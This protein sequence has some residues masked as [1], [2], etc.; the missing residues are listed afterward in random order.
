ME[1][2]YQS[3][4]IYEFFK[5]F[6]T[7]E[8]CLAHLSGLKWKDG[9]K[10]SKCGHGRYCRGAQAM[11]R[12]CTSCRYVESP[13]A[14]TL[15]HKI[16]FPLLKAF[17]IAYFLSTGK[18]GMSST[19]LS[20]KLELR[21]KTCWLFKQKVMRGMES[22][23]KHPL[24]GDVEVDEFVVGQQEEGTRGRGNKRK[25]LVVLAIE[26][27][28]KGVSRMYARHI[29]DGSHASLSPFL[30]DTVSP[31]AAILTD[32]WAGYKPSL[33]DFPAMKQI[34]SGEKGGN[35]PFVHRVIM[36]FKAWLRGI[37]SHAELL[38][39]YL[40]EY[41]FRFNRSFMKKET[42]NNLMAKLIRH[43]PCPYKM[44]IH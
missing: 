38:Q 20:R 25:K 43:D 11:S 31:G 27:K 21:Q 7:E 3:L 22:S 16:K 30:K 18:K 24:E 6:P 19:E 2:K 26:R 5:R 8:S 4:S 10:C 14:G 44:I 12:Q 36:G 28:G 13:T 15:F 23:G 37:H 32:G 42:F 9:Y 35:F 29:K 1:A 17:G 34:L 40:D 33:N 41:C 39:G